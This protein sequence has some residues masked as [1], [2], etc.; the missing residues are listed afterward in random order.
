[1]IQFFD[2]NHVMSHDHIPISYD[3]P[4]RH[5]MANRCTWVSVAANVLLTMGQIVAGV[6]ALWIESLA[7]AA[8]PHRPL[9]C[10]ENPYLTVG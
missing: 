3:D 10:R 8:C 2:K 7:M 4:Q 6:L 9:Y 5:A 1:L